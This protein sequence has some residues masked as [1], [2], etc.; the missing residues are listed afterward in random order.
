MYS[1][2]DQEWLDAR[3]KERTENLKERAWKA[4]NPNIRVLDASKFSSQVAALAKTLTN[5]VEREGVKMFSPAS[6][7]IDT[8]MI[9]RQLMCTYALIG[10]VNADEVRFGTVGYHPPYSFVILPLVR[11]MIDGFYNCTA[12]LDDPRRSRAFRISGY[13]RMRDAIR[14]DEARYPND[15][16]WV[17]SLA[18]RRTALQ[19]AMRVEGLTDVDLDD[20]NNEWPLLSQYLR[21]KPTNTPHKELIRYLTHG[22][23]KEYSSISHVSFDGLI[24]LH[25]FIATD[26]FPHEKRDDVLDDMVLRQLTMHYGR[27]AGILLCLLTEIQHFYKFNG[28]DIDKRLSEIWTAMLPL[29]EVRELFDY[30]YWALLRE[31]VTEPSPQP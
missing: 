9:L 23:W 7:P 31:P 22:F 28:S 30:R 20:R 24:A 27:A 4:L 10:W 5:K 14:A 26:R 18:A 25:P 21:T 1:S 6:I 19:S 12:L 8:G 29:Y 16:E 2:H 3:I 17:P 13:W 15:P 11:T